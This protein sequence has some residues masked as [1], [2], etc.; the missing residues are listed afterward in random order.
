MISKISPCLTCTRVANPRNCEN[1]NCKP[2]QAWFLARWEAIRENYRARMAQ[3]K[4]EPVGITVSGRH[5]AAP[6]Q[7]TSY[8]QNDPCDSCLCSKELCRLPCPGKIAWNKARKD[9][10]L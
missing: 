2:W 6:H 3:S 5:Y 7:V 8:L 9:V 10:L 1:K 4:T